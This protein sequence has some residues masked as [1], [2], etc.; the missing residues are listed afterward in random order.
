[1]ESIK[2]DPQWYGSIQQQAKE[3]GIS[4]EENLRRNAVYVYQTQKK[5]Q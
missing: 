1:M 5:E 3:R 2:N 4:V